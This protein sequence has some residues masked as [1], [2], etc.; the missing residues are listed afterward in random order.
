M[1]VLEALIDPTLNGATTVMTKL[2][3]SLKL[4]VPLSVT[5]TIMTLVVLASAGVVGHTNTPLFVPIIATGGAPGSRLKASICEGI[6]E[7]V[8]EL[9]TINVLPAWIVWLLTGAR[10]G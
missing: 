6:S 9:V 1:V 5:R 8:A 2:F 10:N 7:S 3:V 4:G